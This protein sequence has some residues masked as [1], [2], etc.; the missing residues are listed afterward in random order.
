MDEVSCIGNELKLTDCS[1]D[2]NTANCDQI[3]QD[4][5]GVVCSYEIISKCLALCILLS[6]SL[7]AL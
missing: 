7:Y 5:G 2:R 3:C 6:T 4:A 1:Y